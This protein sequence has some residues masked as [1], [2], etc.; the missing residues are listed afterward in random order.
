MKRIIASDEVLVHFD[1]ELTVKLVCDASQ[2]GVG[3]AL[4]HVFAN[5]TERP[6]A[7][8]S[9]TLAKSERNYS[10]I[11]REALAIHFGV[12]K[13][14]HFL[15]GRKFILKTDHKPLI[16]IFGDK[17][18]IPAMAAGRLQRWSVYWSNFDFTIEYIKGAENVCAD[19]LSRMP[20]DDNNSESFSA[21]Q[22]ITYLNFIENNATIKKEAIRLATAE[23][24]IL[25]EVVG[26]LRTKWP[27]KSKISAEVQPYFQKASE[28]T[29]E[30]DILMWGYRVVVSLKCR[31]RVL[32]QLH[33]AHIGNVRMKSLARS[34]FWWPALDR[35]IE[36]VANGCSQCLSCRPEQPKIRNTSWPKTTYPFERVHIDH[37]GPIAGKTILIIKDSYS[38]WIEAYIVD[39]LSSAVTIEKL[40]DC[41][42]R[43][44]I[45]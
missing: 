33:A 29:I 36:K 27:D 28:L 17:R 31:E 1:P 9:R 42:S 39:S 16:A 24:E 23:D 15:I 19:F 38:K 6:I 14:S 41:F 13:Y 40:R 12:S 25:S 18:G 3:A 21:N 45:I 34:Y 4:M 43:F 30:N 26:Y 8:A 2:H 11:D 32:K 22:Q 7:F 20:I 10:T 5:G 44:G 37:L 35:A